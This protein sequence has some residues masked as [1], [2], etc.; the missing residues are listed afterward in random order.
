MAQRS[1][2]RA[3]DRRWER[4]HQKAIAAKRAKGGAALTQRDFFDLTEE[5]KRQRRGVW[6]SWP[7]ARFTGYAVCKAVRSVVGDIRREYFGTPKAFATRDEYFEWC[8]RKGYRDDEI[9]RRQLAALENNRWTDDDFPP[10]PER[11]LLKTIRERLIPLTGWTDSFALTHVALG[12]GY[13]GTFEYRANLTHAADS[14]LGVPWI[15]VT[16]YPW[17]L[18]EPYLQ[19]LR[20]E[21]Q[22]FLSRN[23]RARA[24]I[25]G[26]GK[27]YDVHELRLLDLL[28]GESAPP[29]SAGKGKRVGR[30]LYWQRLSKAWGRRYKEPVKPNALRMR[31]E[32]FAAKHPEDVLLLTGAAATKGDG[33]KV[34]RGRRVQIWHPGDPQALAAITRGRRAPTGG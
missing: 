25:A 21:M 32:R 12:E 33:V 6:R 20:F 9:G 18:S 24:G 31:W 11:S 13:G 4:L 28:A 1:L 26:W 23:A 3:K 14:G 10:T 8:S 19:R 16:L 17:Q 7:G 2:K 22:T 27:P 5:L 30:T 34:S 29:A 15:R